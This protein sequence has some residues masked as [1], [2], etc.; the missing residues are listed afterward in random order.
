MAEEARCVA[1]RGSHIARPCQL[2]AVL[3]CDARASAIRMRCSVRMDARTIELTSAHTGLGT[4]T[5]CIPSSSIRTRMLAVSTP[6]PD[7]I[8]DCVLATFHQLPDKRKPRPQA[9]GAREWVPLA[10]IVLADKGTA[11]YRCSVT[12]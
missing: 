5:K 8:A 6:G 3:R 2:S 4:T 11:Y 9:D 10:G 12:L 1:K 7:A